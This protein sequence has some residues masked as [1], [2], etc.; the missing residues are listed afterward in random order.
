MIQEKS[1]SIVSKKIIKIQGDD[2]EEYTDAIAVEE[3]LEISISVLIKVSPITN[4]NISITMRT[5]GHDR[6]LAL[7][8]LFTEG[9]IKAPHQITEV[10]IN[11]NSVNVQLNNSEEVDLSKLERHFYTS[12]SCGVCGKTSIDAI[13]TVC[14]LPP[15]P[16]DFR[17]EKNLIKTFP[18]ILQQQQNIFNYTGGIHAAALF[19]TQGQLINVREDVGRHNALDKLIGHSLQQGQLPLNQ[20]LLFLSGRASFELIQKAAMAGIH[21]IMA[22]GAPSSLAIEMAV[23][24]DITLI[25]FL[26]K[27]RYNIYTGANRIKI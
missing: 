26:N 7:G 22:V 8:F 25:G 21:F 11:Q 17:I 20:Y 18:G 14:R 24:H 27:T 12:S 10:I 4:K 6:D 5:P 19:N 16:S 1:R 2:F 23:E 3:P 13:K 9:I 15:S